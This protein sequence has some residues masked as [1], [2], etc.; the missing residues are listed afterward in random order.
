MLRII[1]TALALLFDGPVLADEWK[2]YENRE[3]GFTVH[4]P[5]D[6]SVEMSTYKAAMSA[7]S[8]H[9]SSRS[10]RTLGCSK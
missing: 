8:P 1:V 3:L 5:G 7:R 6:P 4:F 2:E 9:I 10:S